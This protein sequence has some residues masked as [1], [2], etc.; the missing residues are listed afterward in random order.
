MPEP[1]VSFEELAAPAP[2]AKPA[3]SQATTAATEVKTEVTTPQFTEADAEAYRQMVDAGVTPQTYKDFI[4]AKAALANLATNLATNPRLVI[5]E[6]ERTNPQV[7]ARLKQEISDLWF[8]EYQRLN[9]ET[10]Q[11]ANG[12]ASSA[13]VSD[14]RYDQLQQKLDTLIEQ[15]NQELS[16]KAQ[17]AISEG[18]NKAI[19]KLME[20]LPETITE[21]DRDYIRLKTQEFVWKDKDAR[22]RVVKGTYL[23]VPKHF[24]RA[25]TQATADTKAAAQKEIERREGV[26]TRGTKTIVP[27]A[28]PVGGEPVTDKNVD[29]VWGNISPGE[30]N[31]AL[32][33]RR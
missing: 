20:K 24:A 17:D 9:P 15:R 11:P 5:Q 31:A 25:V 28:E 12:S 32:Q 27:A 26:E 30:V 22:E 16:A 29:P 19:E 3:E 23:D 4:E 10:A 18:Y 2:P 1:N 7:A 14:P 21:K 8:E 13:P 33:A 6:I